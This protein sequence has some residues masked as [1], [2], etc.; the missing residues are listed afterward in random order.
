MGQ[1]SR[2]ESRDT[3]AP[4]CSTAK[5]SPPRGQMKSKLFSTIIAAGAAMAQPG[6]FVLREEATGTSSSVQGRGCGSTTTA[7]NR[8]LGMGLSTPGKQLREFARCAGRAAVLKGG[9]QRQALGTDGRDTLPRAMGINQNQLHP[10][11][12]H[13]VGSLGATHPKRLKIITG[14]GNGVPQAHGLNAPFVQTS[15]GD[16]E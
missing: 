14:E 5:I 8:G 4:R 7:P 11:S 16:R 9:S 3:G 15:S 13:R 1:A 10:A 12:C 6:V 2:R